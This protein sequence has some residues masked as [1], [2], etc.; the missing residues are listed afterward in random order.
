[1]MIS[2]IFP[3]L[4]TSAAYARQSRR[5]PKIEH[6]QETII[7]KIEKNALKLFIVVMWVSIVFFIFE[8]FSNILFCYI[9][10]V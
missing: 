7:D 1:M 2:C 5:R 10:L 8:T 9:I 6:A 3:D 4:Y